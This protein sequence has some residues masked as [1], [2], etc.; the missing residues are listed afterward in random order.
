MKLFLVCPYFKYL[1]ERTFQ[2]SV[3]HRL[4]FPFQQLVS[5]SRLMEVMETDFNPFVSP[6]FN[7][8]CTCVTITHKNSEVWT[9]YSLCKTDYTKASNRQGKQQGA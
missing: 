7:S 3:M 1:E 5:C 8:P 6:H 9:H 4:L 2:V